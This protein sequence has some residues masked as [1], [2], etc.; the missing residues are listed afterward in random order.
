TPTAKGLYVP[1][2][3]NHVSLYDDAGGLLDQFGGGGSGLGKF[4]FP[5]GS[6]A[7]ADGNLYVADVANHRVQKLDPAGAPLAVFGSQGSGDGQL[8]TP[9]DVALAPAG[10]VYV[11]DGANNRIEKFAAG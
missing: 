11:A 10:N 7:D 3:P 5:G 4:N 9:R 1:E 6:A 8:N 2:T